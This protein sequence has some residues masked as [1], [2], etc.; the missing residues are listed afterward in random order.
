MSRVID[1]PEHQFAKTYVGTPYY[2]SPVSFESNMNL[3]KWI[4][5]RLLSHSKTGSPPP[6]DPLS[7]STALYFL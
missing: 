5:S 3:E 4:D 7:P 2:M 6:L 1:D